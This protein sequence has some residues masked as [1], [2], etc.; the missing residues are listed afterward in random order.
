MSKK[1]IYLD[2]V[3]D[4]RKK[5][6]QLMKS[7]QKVKQ[8]LMQ[9][10]DFLSV[11]LDENSKD[12]VGSWK[13]F[14]E[15]NDMEWSDSLFEIY[16]LDKESVTKDLYQKYLSFFNDDDKALFFQEMETLR[17]G[18]NK[19]E[20]SY[21]IYLNNEAYKRLHSTGF[22]IKNGQSEV[23]GV[24]GL[25]QD[26]TSQAEG[27]GLKSFFDSSVDLQ[28]IANDAGYF[29]KISPSW[30]KLM[31]YTTEELCSR[32]FIEFVHPDDLVK[33][34]DET[35]K[36]EDGEM[37]LSFENR[38]IT[39]SSEVVT[40]SW[41]AQLDPVTNLFYCTAR[42]VSEEVAF[43]NKI[44][45]DL[46]EKELLLREIHHRVK[47]NLQVISSLLSLQSN[48]KKVTDSVRKLYED[49]QNRIKS[50]AAIHEL[51]YRSEQIGKVNFSNYLEKLA[52]DLIVSYKGDHCNIEV[53]YNTEN[54][55]LDLDL[56]VPLGLIV[57]EIITNALKHG[58]IRDDGRLEMSMKKAGRK[59]VEMII[60]DNGI[61]FDFSLESEET[62]GMVLIS[63]L[64]DQIDGKIQQLKNR[65]GTY[66]KIEF[67]I[68]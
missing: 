20:F 6:D 62:L 56:A 47:N 43:R 67:P 27:Y 2:L 38:Y 10:P 12:Q 16:D 3:D 58:I 14:F 44:L 30:E 1:E 48:L 32:P 37:S 46:T 49:S 39:K 61:G 29:L 5:E 63:G 34:I 55:Y 60:G 68:G 31:G 22:P 18:E 51:F 13:Y 41:N 42:D 17:E 28:C 7:K 57:N 40:L 24:K 21:T 25:V 19:Y 11:S 35:K 9:N 26:V 54:I 52:N 64:I 50:M 66:Y 59:N 65:K 33:T 36:L 23:I 15:K 4:L 8:Y 45:S 53:E